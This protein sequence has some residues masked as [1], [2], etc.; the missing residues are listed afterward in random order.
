MGHVAK[1]NQQAIDNALASVAKAKQDKEV[2]Q[3][4]ENSKGWLTPWGAFRVFQR[5]NQL[6]GVA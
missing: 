2:A 5:S 4:L 6:K 1:Q 3:I